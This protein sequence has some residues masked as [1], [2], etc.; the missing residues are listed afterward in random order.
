MKTEN[1]NHPSHNPK[2]KQPSKLNKRCV[3]LWPCDLHLKVLRQEEELWK[4]Q[5]FH[6]AKI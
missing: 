2:S 1:P 5:I 3:T 6:R 4:T